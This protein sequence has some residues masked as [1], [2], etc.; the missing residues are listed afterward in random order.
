MLRRLGRLRRDGGAI[1][2]L[3]AVM[4]PLLLLPVGAIAIDVGYWFVM[5][6]KVQATADAGA[7]AAANAING[8]PANASVVSQAAGY[9]KRN[10]D[11]VTSPCGSPPCYRVD[12]PYD[13]EISEVEV[14]VRHP[15]GTFFGGIVGLLGVEVSRRAVAHQTRIPGT[16]AIYV[17][18]TL[19]HVATAANRWSSTARTSTSRVG[20]TPKAGCRSRRAQLL[21]RGSGRP[22]ARS[23]GETRRHRRCRC[24]RRASI[25]ARTPSS[26]VPTPTTTGPIPLPR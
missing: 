20:S 10:M 9:V 14:E 1:M 24:A 15:A 23:D 21:S 5:Q 26:S 25:R 4:V 2:V 17:H 13:G 6:R 7:L 19:P 12:Y 18:S 8:N 16:M 3:F 22:R 11:T